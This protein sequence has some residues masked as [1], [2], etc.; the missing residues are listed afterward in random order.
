MVTLSE[1][2]APPSS[3]T[4]RVNVYDL[5]APSVGAMKY[6]V[7]VSPSVSATGPVH[8]HFAMVPSESLLPVPSRSTRSPSSTAWSDPASASGRTFG[9]LTLTLTSMLA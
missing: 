2:V 3:V 8:S 6:G 4:V 9:C 7:E 1:S 5:V